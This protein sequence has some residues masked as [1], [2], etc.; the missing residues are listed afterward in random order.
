ML[1]FEKKYLESLEKKYSIL[2]KDFSE[3]NDFTSVYQNNKKTQKEA[4]LKLF[5]SLKQSFISYLY[6]Y[7]KW[8]VG[9]PHDEPKNMCRELF[10][11][12]II[13]KFEV[14]YLIEFFGEMDNN[15]INLISDKSEFIS[16]IIEK[17]KPSKDDF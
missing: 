15:L 4:F 2:L 13:T 12:G 3:F 1:D 14:E 10:R 8:V 17:I 5:I 6:L 9:L 11:C 7:L 16:T